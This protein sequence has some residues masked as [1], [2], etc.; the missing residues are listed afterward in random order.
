MQIL[1]KWNVK[2]LKFVTSNNCTLLFIT[3]LCW[4]VLLCTPE[5]M[6]IIIFNIQVVRRFVYHITRFYSQIYMICPRDTIPRVSWH[7]YTFFYQLGVSDVHLYE[8]LKVIDVT[9]GTSAPRFPD[10]MLNIMIIMH[11]KTQQQSTVMNNMVQLFDVTNFN[12]L[13]FH[14]SKICKWLIVLCMND[15]NSVIQHTIDS[16]GD[17]LGFSI[18]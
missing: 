18:I 5:C 3:V 1:N 16:M 7:K 8:R 11:N 9:D 13:T 12:S 6:I 4:C 17:I 15:D 14:L 2:P 10:L